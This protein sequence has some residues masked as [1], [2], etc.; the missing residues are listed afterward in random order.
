MSQPTCSV[1]IMIKK[2][3]LGSR[4]T[5]MELVKYNELLI[6]IVKVYPHIYDNTKASYQDEIMKDNPWTSIAKNFKSNR[7]VT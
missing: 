6:M 2:T 7:K 5:K 1:I 4:D 3:F